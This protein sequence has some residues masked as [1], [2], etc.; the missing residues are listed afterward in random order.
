VRPEPGTGR[1]VAVGAGKR[2]RTKLTY[3]V[4]GSAFHDGAKTTMADLVYSTMF[5][6]R[7]GARGDSDAHYDPFIGAA[8]ATLRQN[9][10]ALRTVGTDAGSKSFRVAD[11]NFVRE[12]FIIEVYASIAPEDPEQEAAVLPPWSTLPWHVLVLMEEAVSRG[13][14]AFSQG[15][16]QRRGVEW[17]DLVRSEQTNAKLAALVETFA[18]DGYRPEPLQSGVSAEDARKRWTALAAFYKSDGHFLVTNGPYRL[19]RWSADSVTLEAFR[20]LSYPLGVGSFDAYAIPRRG[21]VTAVAW[22]GNRA[23][24]KGDIEVLEKF[25]RSYRLVR[26]ALQS[27][28]PE[29]AKRAAPE[30]RYTIVDDQARVVLTGLI[31]LAGDSTFQIDLGGRLPEGSY[32][33]FAMIAVAGNAM[34]A[35]IRRVPVTVLS[36]P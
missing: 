1:L 13:F 4:L 27:L 20:D 21:F 31:K 19:K 32:T 25:Q 33:M 35:E 17:L 22:S 23:T 15:E 30:C 10:V 8:T 6:Y 34:N 18:R 9:L 29:T 7:W 36:T 24:L 28:A 16:A 12:L 14:A 26:T 2:A 5:A 11:V 3:R